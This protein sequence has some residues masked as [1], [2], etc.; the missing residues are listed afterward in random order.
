MFQQLKVKAQEI[1]VMQ[2]GQSIRIKYLLLLL[3]MINSIA[4]YSFVILDN[5]NSQFKWSLEFLLF[6]MQKMTKSNISMQK[7]C[8]DCIQPAAQFYY[9][10]LKNFTSILGIIIILAYI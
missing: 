2:Y 1:S 10:R 6:D 8:L 3:Y 9:W 4:L 7:K 5:Y